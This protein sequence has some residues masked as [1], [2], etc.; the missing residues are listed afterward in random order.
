MGSIYQRAEWRCSTCKTRLRKTSE[1]EACKRAGHDVNEH[2]SPI[3][4]IKYTRAGKSY[5]ESSG[6]ER[7]K[8][9]TALLQKKEGDI[10]DGKPVTPK[11][12]KMFF[13]EAA[14]DVLADY[15]INKKRSFK[16]VERRIAKHLTP[17]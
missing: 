4:W 11:I 7:K 10:V 1:R 13:E 14:N 12:G 16:V 9:A 15:T 2:R 8:D 3:Y 17:F 5:N 6:S